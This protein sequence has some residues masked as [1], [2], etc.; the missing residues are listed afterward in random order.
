M[1]VMEIR[2]YSRSK[3]FH[4]Q[5]IERWLRLPEEDQ[6]AV[7]E[8]VRQLKLG[9]NH[10]RDFLDWLEEITLRDR[11]PIY[12]VLNNEA[13]IKALSDARLGRNDKLNRVKEEL[14]RIRFPWLCQVEDSIHE[15]IRDLKVKRGIRMTVPRGLEGAALTVELRATTHEE[16]KRRIQELMEIAEKPS[17]HEIFG[18]LTAREDHAGF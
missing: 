12:T 6:T 15:R 4:R 2:D 13:L 17:L 11:V 3:G 14:R 8:L 9:E 16:F 1:P 5:T 7:L 10:L 18:L